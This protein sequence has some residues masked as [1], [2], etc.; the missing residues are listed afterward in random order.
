MKKILILSNGPV[1]T[2]EQDKVE[3]GGLRCW[4]LANG[5]LGQKK[6]IEITLAYNDVFKKDDSP[7]EFAGINLKTWQIQNI[8]ELISE[9]DSVIVS[10]SMGDLTDSVVSNIRDDQ[11]LILDGY[12]P[13]YIEMSARDSD[14]IEREYDAFNFENK[15]WTRA[16]KRGDIILCANENQKKFYRGVLSSLGRI[17]PVT[18]TDDDFIKIV[19]YGVYKESPKANNK[20]IT[21]ILKNKDSFKL[22]WFGG[23]Y[24]WFDLKDLLTAIKEISKHKPVELIMVGVKN[25]FNM[26]PDFLAKYDE[27]IKFI[28]D[29]KLEQIV[30]LV[31][32]VKFDDRADWYLD[33]DAVILINKIGVENT[34]AWRTRL[35]DY[36]WADLPIITNGGDPLSDILEENK[37][38]KILTSLEKDNL[39]KEISGFIDDKDSLKN[40]FKNMQK[41]RSTLYW[42][43]VTK[44][45]SK[46]IIESYKPKDSHMRIVNSVDI[47]DSS[48]SMGKIDRIKTISRKGLRFAKTNG[49]MPATKI[50]MDKVS[51]KIKSS[52]NVGT[53]PRIIIISHQLDNTG[54]PFVAID[55]AESIKSKYPELAN[56]IRFISFTPASQENLRR[57]KKS[58]IKT[59]L[60]TDKNLQM[61]YNKGDIV[62][63]N[64]FGLSEATVVST[65]NAAKN[66]IIKKIYWY[67]HEAE[68]DAFVNKGVKKQFKTL[69]QNNKASLY[70]V[71]K[72]SLREYQRFFETEQNIEKMPFRFVFSEEDFAIKPAKE[73]DDKIKF[74][75]T[76]AVSD[77]RKG[78]L[79]VLYA[80]LDFYNNRY[81]SN[82]EKYRDFELKYI[83]V[84]G[85]YIE[86]QMQLSGAGLGNKLNIIG[87]LSHKD[88]LNEIKKS[89]MTICYSVH[90]AMGIFVYEGMSYGHPIIRNEAAG[91]EEQLIEGV[92]GFG[93]DSKDFA[94]LVSVIDRILDKNQTSS[95]LLAKM[96]KESNKIAKKATVA[97]YYIIDEIKKTFNR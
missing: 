51:R 67:G 69:L 36:V 55:L 46:M 90:E 49:V 4:G 34:L 38:V 71:S 63:L 65:M 16:L 68:P 19:P 44:D 11:Q 12:V 15:I 28:K 59:E 86:K 82:T 3:G 29:N 64:S 50:V 80:F 39:V 30:H 27:I 87:K 70:A 89:N 97:N 93:V 26:H 24:P 77:G 79:P 66:N 41:V 75:I 17:N 18:Y 84:D 23:I 58:G 42:D 47:N 78:Q 43:V 37:A 60:F 74:I 95:A 54:A 76:G 52:S 73:F 9:Y 61:S 94:G 31:D 21:K 62:I 25:P 35:V 33:S 6:K 22:L 81:L 14:N 53:K 88:A 2:P 96:S 32:W 40:I 48:S 13:I 85:G 56:D 92:D 8:P 5:L 83:G 72:G 7:T 10:Y 91:Q 45:L 1:P 57:L 20:P